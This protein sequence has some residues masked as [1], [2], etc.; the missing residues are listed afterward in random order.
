MR[1]GGF[2]DGSTD[3]GEEP[4]DGAPDLDEFHQ[5]LCSASRRRILYYLQEHPEIPLEELSD[6]VAGWKA[7][8]ENTVVGPR[9]RDR[10]RVSLHHTDV[11]R[12]ADSDV[13]AYDRENR[14]VSLQPLPEPLSRILRESREYERERR[15]AGAD[16]ALPEP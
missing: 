9:E 15:S 16:E 13:V 2:D 7:V 4:E 6:V 3:R 14:E 8:E 12:L 5:L 10:I 1:G 11:P